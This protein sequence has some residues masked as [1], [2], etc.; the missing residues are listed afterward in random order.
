VY[1]IKHHVKNAH[2]LAAI[3]VV[4]AWGA[5][6]QTAVDKTPIDKT[7]APKFEVASIKPADPN[8]PDSGSKR[9]QAGGTLRLELP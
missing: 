2:T 4:G 1:P 5:L 8:V 6:G 7:E 9:L 3:L